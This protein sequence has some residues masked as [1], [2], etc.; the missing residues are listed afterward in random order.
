MVLFHCSH[1]TLRRRKGSDGLGSKNLHEQVSWTGPV[2]AHSQEWLPGP[3]IFLPQ[4][5]KHQA[6]S[7]RFVAGFDQYLVDGDVIRLSQSMNHGCGHVFGGQDAGA[8]RLS[9]LLERLGIF[10]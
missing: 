10:T 2:V 5:R 3:D 7:N 1:C 4:D 8:G 6:G 9:V